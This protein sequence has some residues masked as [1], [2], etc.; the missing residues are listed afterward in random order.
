MENQLEPRFSTSP[1]EFTPRAMLNH[2]LFMLAHLRRFN[3]ADLALEKDKP[4][5]N[6][7]H[8]AT[9]LGPIKCWDD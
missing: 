6:E 3:R 8:Y 9:L 4:E 1:P 5:R 2:R 7:A